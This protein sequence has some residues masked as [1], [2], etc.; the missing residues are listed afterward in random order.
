MA[1]CEWCKKESQ[2]LVEIQDSM[3]T[4]ISVC[5]K[6]YESYVRTSRCRRCK[7][8]VTINVNG[9]CTQCLQVETLNENK[10]KQQALMGVMGNETIN[11]YDELVQSTSDSDFTDEEFDKWLQIGHAFT[12]NDM[13]NSQQLKFIWVLVKLSAT[14]L[15]ESEKLNDIIKDNMS[16]IEEL[17]NAHLKDIHDFLN[18]QT[19]L[20]RRCKLIIDCNAETRRIIKMAK[21]II[22]SHGNVYIVQ[23]ENDEF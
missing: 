18:K 11:Q 15:Y 17:L 2:N 10:R 16:D 5:M 1:K 3:G 6:C 12:F 4:D 13:Q 20:N 23:L 8:P 21:N 7:Q 19:G 14:G 22:A 9:L